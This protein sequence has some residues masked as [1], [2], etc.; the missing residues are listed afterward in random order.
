MKRL[1][2]ISNS[3]RTIGYDDETGKLEVEFHNGRRYVSDRP[4]GQRLFR[5]FINATSFGGFFHSEIRPQF[6]MNEVDPS[7]E[8]KAKDEEPGD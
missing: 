4:V 1:P 6:K 8:S 3:I 7:K 2:V 5:R